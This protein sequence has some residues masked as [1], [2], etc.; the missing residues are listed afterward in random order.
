MLKRLYVEIF[1]MLVVAKKEKCFRRIKKAKTL[2]E[3][4]YWARKGYDC[5]V[6]FKNFYLC[7]IGIG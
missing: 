7:E 5:I 3:R 2:E 1:F 4:Y 6:W